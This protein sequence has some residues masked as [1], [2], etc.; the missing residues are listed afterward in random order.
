MYVEAIG[1]L[2][3]PGN[4]RSGIAVTNATTAAA[5]AVFELFR[6]DGSLAATRTVNIPASGQFV[7][8]L[9]D[10]ELFPAIERPFRGVLR[11]SS[12][13][14]IG[15]VGLRGRYN[16]RTPASDF[17][18]TTTPPTLESAPATAAEQLFPQ[19]VN[20]GGYTTQ[21]VVFSGTA[22]QTSA[23]V[24]RFFRTDGSAFGLNLN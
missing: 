24:L 9:D 7:R 3:Q 14:E 19:L 23:G 6:L 10:A 20:G 21:F 17:L 8:F 11:I 16:E 15:V 1:T 12:A 13:A 2:G 18:I 22:G 5:D 4:I